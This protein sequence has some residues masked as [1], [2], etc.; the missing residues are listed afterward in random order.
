MV[1]HMKIYRTG[2]SLISN[3]SLFVTFLFVLSIG[4]VKCEAPFILEKDH[5]S[6]ITSHM[7]QHN[8]TTDVHSIFDTHYEEKE[9]YNRFGHKSLIPLDTWDLY[10][11]FLASLGLILAA[12]GGIGGGGILV[13]I[14]TLV[15]HFTP[16]YAIPLSN[17]SVFGGAVANVILNLRK[18]HPIADRPLVDWD[19]ILIMEPLT[20]GGALIGAAINKLL[21]EL[22]LIILL[23]IVLSVTSYR[24]LMKGVDLYTKENRE[25]RMNKPP[26]LEMGGVYL[27]SEST[28][29]LLENTDSHLDVIR[30]GL[31]LEI[32]L[33]TPMEDPVDK[34]KLTHSTSN[35]LINDL[36][37]QRDADCLRQILEKEKCIPFRKMCLIFLLFSVVVVLN[38]LKGGGAEQS[39]VGIVCNSVSFWVIQ[40][41]V[42]LWVFLIAYLVR[43]CLLKRTK[44]K[45]EVNYPYVEG[46]II[47]D[48]RATVV[49]PLICSIAG[50]F[51][52]MF[53]VGGGIVKGP[54]M[55]I[56]GVHP[57]VA[58]A[59]S[60]TM[61]L[62][63]SLTATTSFIIHGL[64]EYE[65]AVVLGTVGFVA[66]VIGQT[67]MN[68]LIK[69]SG[70]TSYIVLAIGVVVFLS[71]ILIAVDSILSIS[72][73][74]Q[75]LS[76]EKANYSFCASGA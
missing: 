24:M 57:L 19:L 59:T 50:L 48:T 60:A 10:G 45:E 2:R 13:P 66:T 42:L 44:L 14:Y 39:P 20:I 18:R 74:N 21:P 25:K 73:K 70:R 65:Y 53:G 55:L 16:K 17:V 61:I 38:I 37:N 26:K 71:A 11:I 49:Y 43:Q 30:T 8:E 22:L 31:E 62:F 67:I 3:G 68:S 6:K 51:A 76:D 33:E 72:K 63:T 1:Q 34:N 12:G 23:V 28:E 40:G 52:G 5:V 56:M 7:L 75:G 69:K 41:A 58:A 54:L 32:E 29:R 9:S 47:W 35:L 36:K 64:L 15:L 4:V 46:D 27:P